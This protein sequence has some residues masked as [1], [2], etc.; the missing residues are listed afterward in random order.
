[1]NYSSAS[2]AIKHLSALVE[3]AIKKMKFRGFRICACVHFSL[4]TEK[5]LHKIFHIHL[6]KLPNFTATSH[7]F[8]KPLANVDDSHCP[9]Q[10][11]PPC[12]IHLMEGI[13][14]EKCI[15]MYSYMT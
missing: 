11:Y 8:L 14:F 7:Y 4:I 15:S 3:L 1:M 5:K 6:Y 10:S 12:Q 9:N 13:Q 2:L